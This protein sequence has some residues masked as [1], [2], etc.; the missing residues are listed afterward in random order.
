MPHKCL[1]NEGMDDKVKKRAAENRE[2]KAAKRSV[3]S[4]RAGLWRVD[5]P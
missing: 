3:E 5:R 4:G 2:T 1:L